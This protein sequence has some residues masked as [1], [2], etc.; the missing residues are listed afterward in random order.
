MAPAGVA[1]RGSLARAHGDLD[2]VS[3]FESHRLESLDRPRNRCTEHLGELRLLSSGI[4]TSQ[5]ARGARAEAAVIADAAAA[6]AHAL[7]DG[8]IGR[9]A[10][11]AT[12]ICTV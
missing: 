9:A 3:F 6:A 4:G 12:W 8:A 11:V 7:L 2:L 5:C 1:A 10:A